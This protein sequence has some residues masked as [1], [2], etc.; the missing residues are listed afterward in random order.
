MQPGRTI[1]THLSH[2][3]L[4]ADGEKLPSGFE[5]AYDGMEFDVKDL[6]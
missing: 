6:G 1:L 5:F 3:V 4:Y 2:D